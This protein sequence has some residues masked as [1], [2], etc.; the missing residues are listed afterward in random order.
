MSIWSYRFVAV[1]LLLFRPGSHLAWHMCL[2]T[3]PNPHC[4][5]GLA[6]VCTGGEHIPMTEDNLT[7]CAHLLTARHTHP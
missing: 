3:N 2:H 1:L 7:E 5:H 6:P 4:P